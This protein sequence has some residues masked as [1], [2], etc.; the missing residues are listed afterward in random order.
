MNK[1]F[2]L[3]IVSGLFIG[4]L[5]GASFT[6]VIENDMLSIL[7]G[8]LAGVFIGWFIAATVQIREWD[9]K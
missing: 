1:K 5:F 7:H 9:R 4:A 3:Y 2:A 6:P 8:A